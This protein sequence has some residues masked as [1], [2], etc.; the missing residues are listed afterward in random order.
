MELSSGTQKITVAFGPLKVDEAK[1]RQWVETDEGLRVIP[2]IA[3]AADIDIFQENTNPTVT[4]T[5]NLMRF[6]REAH[7]LSVKINN[8]LVSD[9]RE[10]HGSE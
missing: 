2:D 1:S 8:N 5:A 9:L 10:E 3:F 7:E 6:I 4:R